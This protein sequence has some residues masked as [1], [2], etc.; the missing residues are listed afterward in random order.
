MAKI[1]REA[2]IIS[3][4]RMTVAGE[5]SITIR[6]N[7]RSAAWRKWNWD[8]ACTELAKYRIPF[9]RWPKAAWLVIR[10]M[11]RNTR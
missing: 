10:F 8:F 7:Q 1:P 11:W 9:W 3:A 5:C 6:L 4:P 2:L